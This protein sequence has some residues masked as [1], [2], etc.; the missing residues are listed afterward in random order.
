MNTS[1][2]T[3]APSIIIGGSGTG[4]QTEESDPNL[5]AEAYANLVSGGANAFSTTGSKILILDSGSIGLAGYVQYSQAKGETLQEVEHNQEILG[6][7]AT[8]CRENGITVQVDASLAADSGGRVDQWGTA[9]AQAN[10][11]IS[12]IDNVDEMSF[13]SNLS[14]TPA[15]FSLQAQNEVGSVKTLIA[16]YARLDPTYDMGGLKVGDM[17]GGGVEN[18][19]DITAWWQ[20][21]DSAA[22]I[23][24]LP[25][26]SF[27]I[28]DI[29]WDCP[30]ISS[31]T[32]SV[33]QNW[34]SGLSTIGA[35]KGIA[36][37][38]DLQG[39][40]TTPSGSQ[41]VSQVEQ[42]AIM[43]AASGIGFDSVMVNTWQ[44]TPG[45]VTGVNSADSIANAAV[46]VAAILPLYQAGDITFQGTATIE[47]SAQ[48]II[49]TGLASSLGSFTL[50]ANVSN[51]PS[52]RIGVVL[53]DQTGTLTATQVGSGTVDQLGRNMIALTGN[54]ADLTSELAS[55]K[56]LE[57]AS[58]PDTLNIQTFN[59]QGQT[60]EQ[61]VAILALT[62]G[63]D[64]AGSV[65]VPGNQSWISFS[66][67]L[68][69]GHVIETETTDWNRSS[70]AAN[71]SLMFVPQVAVHEPLA[72]YGV[73]LV[74]GV[75]EDVFDP[76]IDNA[77]MPPG[78]FANQIGQNISLT[79]FTS[80]LGN[81][82]DPASQISSISVASTVQEFDP[83]SGQLNTVI[84]KLCP[85]SSTVVDINGSSQ[86]NQFATA[87]ESGGTQI[88]QNNTG[89]NLSWQIGWGDQFSS[90]TLTY[91]GLGRLIEEFLQGNQSNKSFSIDDVF[92][93]STGAIWEQFQSSP[94]P[95]GY[96]DSVTGLHFV[97]GPL[98]VTEFNTGDNPNWDYLDWGSNAVVTEA[99]TDYFIT[100]VRAS[101]NLA[102]NGSTIDV[103]NTPGMISID[104]NAPDRDEV[105]S[106]PASAQGG[107]FGGEIGSV[108]SADPAA[109]CISVNAWGSKGV[110]QLTG[111]L[112]GGSTLIGGD[113]TTT[114]VGFGHDVLIAGQGLSAISTGAGGSNV[115]LS[116]TGVS[117]V[118]IKSGGNDIIQT[119]AATA[120]VS[121]VGL[122]V[123]KLMLEGGGTV[124]IGSGGIVTVQG[125]QE[126]LV[127]SGKNISINASGQKIQ[128]AASSALNLSGSGNTLTL[129][130][131]SLVNLSG[132]TGN[133][134][135]NNV[136][137]NTVN[138]GPGGDVVLQGSGGFVGVGGTKVTV[139]ASGT[140]IQT[141]AGASLNL[142]GSGNTLT[143]GLGSLVNLSGGTG[144]VVTNNV[145]GDTVNVGSGGG[146][147][148]QGT[149][150]SVSVSGAKATLNASGTQIQT[151]ASSALN[152]SGSGNTLTLGLGSLVNL[153]GGTGN[154]VT[155]NVA[156]NTVNIGP[157]GDVV[158][159]GSGG[160]VGVGGTKVTVSASGTQIQTAAGASLNLSGSGNTL[161]LGLG[162]LVNLSGGT[163]NV[164]TNNVA[165]DTV[166][167]G[168]GGGVL[169]Q[170]TGSSVSVSGAKA[171]LNASGTQIQTAASSALNLSGSGNTLTL[172]LGSL[173]NL[174][175]GT[176]NVVTNNVAGNTVN[177][178]PGGDVVLQG[179]GGFVGVGG[180][181]ITLAASGEQISMMPGSS[182]SILGSNNHITLGGRGFVNIR[183]GTGNIIA[184]DMP[185]DCVNFS[186][187]GS[188]VVLGGGGT[189]V[190]NSNNVSVSSSDE[191]IRMADNASLKLSGNN[192]IIHMGFNNMMFLAGGGNTM[193]VDQSGVGPVVSGFSASAGDKLDLR[194]LL[195][196]ANISTDLV[197]LGSYVSTSTSGSD[198]II[199]ILSPLSHSNIT[200][201]G[202]PQVAL[203]TLITDHA[204]IVH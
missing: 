4:G 114:L 185:D 142:S 85:T 145:A 129:G 89:S 1:L 33:W 139:S 41:Y 191:N 101:A 55:I 97:T 81:V 7:I 104:L 88:V 57:A 123:D 126:S 187:S 26:I 122:Y 94:P 133:V 66:A 174:S 98:Y 121:N 118:T 179:S 183:G 102:V 52:S 131:G 199:S 5:L 90:A 31:V 178:G 87:F 120:L 25:N 20:A 8:Y 202:L 196:G 53:V 190:I 23:A 189:I 42:K 2:G 34:L 83:V 168:S 111:L 91:D 9:A 99:W 63:Q 59:A 177:I 110:V 149:G 140:Q 93:P 78:Q 73:E 108:L 37:Y 138:I 164:V 64:T 49:T 170:G 157:G 39:M 28:A 45:P 152:L 146:V 186:G 127:I 180:R 175:G 16:D 12:A 137:G 173:V 24:G 51:D 115:K 62:S 69:E 71:G 163:G 197:N 74:N 148:L 43:L 158:L 162:S 112:S 61:S 107:R 36:L 13:Q 117:N 19:P 204:L 79:N 192:N 29:S 103:L 135:T 194:G 116:A 21:Y 96:V 153:S 3:A 169:L 125:G 172:G 132:G 166:N 156:G 95:D 188:A 75:I 60:D 182:Q 15:D 100:S 70:I 171:T 128:T 134:V 67:T 150:S 77:N 54:L 86:I 32:T 30:W 136:A 195:A 40:L 105:A 50:K 161:T 82:F 154:V 181:F 106:A 141:A 44:P 200:L 22:E 155:N 203:S 147:L 72:E 27:V 165:G 176:G 6:K 144:N 151:A 184:N 193:I 92:D 167:V 80:W 201:S 58:G 198:T 18:L 113:G 159:Q 35:S 48:N 160:F 14:L 68:T 119:G 11:P 124:G 143:L 56:L 17:E 76:Q 84:N 130:L 46:E 38:A 65:S 47:S 109:T 10:L